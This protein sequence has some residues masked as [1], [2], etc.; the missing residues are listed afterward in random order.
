MF[1]SMLI[2][3]IAAPLFMQGAVAQDSDD[4]IV[5]SQEFE[6]VRGDWVLG[7]RVLTP[8]GV[9]IGYIEDLII[10]KENGSVNA[11]VISVGGF[12]G[13][14]SKEIAVDWSEL[15]LNYDA[16]DVRLGIT[17]EEAEEAPEYIFRG[18]E[19]IPVEEPVTTDGVG[20]GAG[21]GTGATTGN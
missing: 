3:G 11:A 13:F 2:A 1:R 18:R 21:T 12:L 16:N 14:G 5:E 8:E 4:V 9:R 15:E 6:E 10:G 20:T 19:Q 7:A 17:Q